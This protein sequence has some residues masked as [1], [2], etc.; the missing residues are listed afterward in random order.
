MKTHLKANN[1]LLIRLRKEKIKDL[2][3]RIFDL[4]KENKAL[5]SGNNMLRTILSKYQK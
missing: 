4:E 2:E 1:G 5:L 3:N